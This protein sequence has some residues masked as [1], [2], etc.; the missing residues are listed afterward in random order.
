V[1]RDADGLAAFNEASASVFF[2]GRGRETRALADQIRAAATGGPAVL[3]LGG[4]SGCGKSSLLA[5]ELVPHLRADRS[6]LVLAP[7]TPSND[8]VTRLVLRRDRS[9]PGAGLGLAAAAVAVAGAENWPVK[10]YGQHRGESSR[11]RRNG[12]GRSH[13]VRFRSSATRAPGARRCPGSMDGPH[14]G[15]GRCSASLG[16]AR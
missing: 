9:G 6:W 3:A 8:P 11:S 1:L 4:P 7:F 2:F 14:H 15:C 12:G 16:W 10:F 13:H 5:A